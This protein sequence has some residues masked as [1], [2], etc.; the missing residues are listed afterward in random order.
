MNQWINEP[1]DKPS[2]DVILNQDWLKRWH[3][4]G[5][6][7]SW[8]RTEF[9]L[10]WVYTSLILLLRHQDSEEGSL[11]SVETLSRELTCFNAWS[12]GDFS[13][14]QDGVTGTEF[15]F[16]LETTTKKKKKKKMKYDFQTLGGRH[17]IVIP[18]IRKQVPWALWMPHLIPSKVSRLQFRKEQLKRHWCSPWVSSFATCRVDQVKLKIGSCTWRTRKK[19]KKDADQFWLVDGTYIWHLSREVASE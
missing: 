3:L 16:P 2:R 5:T 19:T 9:I 15:T 10:G 1:K 13:S 18:E 12:S 17:N 11:F 4:G 7:I 14:E 8:K 6:V